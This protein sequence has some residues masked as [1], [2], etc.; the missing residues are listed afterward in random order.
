M[1]IWLLLS[2]I[3]SILICSS[4]SFWLVTNKHLLSA[5]YET[6]PQ[7]G[8]S[9]GFF[10]FCCFFFLCFLTEKWQD[11]FLCDHLVKL[12]SRWRV[13]V[14]SHYWGVRHSRWMLAP[15]TRFLFLSLEFRTVTPVIGPLQSGNGGQFL[16]SREGRDAGRSLSSVFLQGRSVPDQDGM[17]IL[18]LLCSLYPSVM[19][20]STS[21]PPPQP[22]TQKTSSSHIIPAS[23]F[24]RTICFFA[25][26]ICEHIS[27]LL[28]E[29][30]K[31][32]LSFTRKLCKL[33]WRPRSV[34]FSFKQSCFMKMW[35]WFPF[36]Y[37]GIA[38]WECVWGEH[39]LTWQS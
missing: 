16:V 12:V 31:S 30:L 19:P 14:R 36:P 20:P 23:V 29:E 22:H 1:G 6:L 28:C 27:S 10:A 24:P 34:S 39:C 32:L 15:G 7:P 35:F 9:C 33:P 17:L 3:T 26:L 38:E 25:N 11:N 21:T 8:L 13:D 37:I 18:L 4:I 5:V 2:S